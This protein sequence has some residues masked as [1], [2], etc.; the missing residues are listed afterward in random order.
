MKLWIR[1][2]EFYIHKRKDNLV[3]THN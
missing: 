1:V 3:L 2:P